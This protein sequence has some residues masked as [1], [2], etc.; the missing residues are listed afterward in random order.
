MK[1]LILGGVAEAK[2][3]ATALSPH[4]TVTYSIA[5]L[6]RTPSLPCRIRSGGFHTAD[7]DGAEGLAIYCQAEHIDLLLDATHPYAVEISAHAATA[8][9]ATAIPC[10]RLQRPGWRRAD[11]PNWHPYRD[12][13]DLARQLHA[14]HRPFFSIGAAA[15]D[16]VAARPPHQCWVVRSARPFAPPAGVIP[17]HAIGPFAYADEHRLLRAHRIDALI[18]KDSGCTRV[19]HKL[20][21]ARDLAIPAFIQTRPRLAA[22]AR[23]FTHINA[24]VAAVN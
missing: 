6:V 24:L 17:I 4:H 22:V 21:A 23:E 13:A 7:H 15:L 11:Y 8:A 19:I 14:Y 18:S 3:L 10:W 2:I 20:A 9:T 12:W 16:W 5:G 1:I